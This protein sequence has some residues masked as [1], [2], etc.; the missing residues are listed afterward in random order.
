MKLVAE[1]GATKIQWGIVQDNN[2]YE[3]ITSGFNP[4]VSDRNYLRQL[5]VS[6]FPGNFSSSDIVEIQYYGAGCGND[7]NKNE[8]KRALVNFFT[9]VKNVEI[10][11]DLEAAG[12]A[13]FKN[14]SGFVG[15]LGTGSS[16]G[17]YDEG[18]IIKQAP[19]LGYLLGDEGSGAH[20]GKE[21]ITK[22]LHNELTKDL[23]KLFYE[24]YST[25][26][27]QLIKD[28]YQSKTPS[29]FLANFS[30]FLKDHTR[31]TLLNSIILESLV[32]F[33]ERYILPM[34]KGKDDIAIGFVGGVAYAFKPEINLILVQNKLTSPIIIQKPFE[35]LVKL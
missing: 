28:L 2:V 23:E 8:V 24:K 19:S 31:D 1:A 16:F 34:V 12:K 17:Y 6:G 5:L 20:M 13:I 30:M 27:Q 32:S 18:Q 35:H 26:S 29:A 14:E 4:N 22:L 21:L 10:Y 9:N 3:F 25:N 15:V 33:V 11:S 7:K